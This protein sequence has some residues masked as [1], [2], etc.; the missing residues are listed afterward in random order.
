MYFD[1]AIFVNQ[2]TQIQANFSVDSVSC[3]GGSDGEATANVVG[4][5]STE[6]FI[7]ILGQ[8]VQVILYQMFTAVSLEA[9]EYTCVVS[10]DNGCSFDT[11]V[12]VSQPDEIMVT[13]DPF[14]FGYDAINDLHMLV[15]SVQMMVL[16][17]Q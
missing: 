6:M 3:W 16:L 17:L 4:G 2:P 7:I 1:D 14:I 13:L 12:I 8:M 10:D 9:G 15:V 11:T 5:T